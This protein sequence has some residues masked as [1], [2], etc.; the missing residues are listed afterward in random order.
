[1]EVHHRKSVAWKVTLVDT[2]GTAKQ[3]GALDASVII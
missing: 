2:G 1:M 3:A